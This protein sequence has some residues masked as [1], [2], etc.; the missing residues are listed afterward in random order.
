MFKTDI[1]N[2]ISL[3]GAM[4]IVR[5]KTVERSIEIAEGCL[6]GG[7]DVL[8]ISYTLP[9]A[10][11]VISALN[12]K[13]GNKLL[14]GAGTVLDTE[15]ARLAILSGAKFIIAPNFSRE[16]AKTSNRYQ[17][18]YAPGCTTVTEM[19]QALEAGASFIK[20]FP[21]SN[22]YG[23]SLTLVLKTPIPNMPILA[24][25]GVNFDNLEEWI[26]NGTDCIAFGSL[27]TKGSKDDIAANA[28]KIREAIV[29]HRKN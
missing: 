27:L 8:E 13:F 15:T 7:I 20:A 3:T 25:G 22:F 23:P 28:R 21:I 6:K 4:A 9:N 12:N 24:S 14:V 17:I 29:N 26:K 16:V 1:V 2:R 10:G 5:A 11:H 18:P 19:I